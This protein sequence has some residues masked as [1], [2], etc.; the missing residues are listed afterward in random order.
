MHDAALARGHGI[1]AEWL[2][3]SLHAFSGNARRHAQFFKTQRAVAAAIDVYLF[4]ESRFQPQR[5]EGEVFERFQKFRA[6]LQENLFVLAVEIGEHFR[7]ASGAFSISR[8]RVYVYL[9]LE[10]G[11]THHSLQKMS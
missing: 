10:R 3:R 5:P 4:M 8:N 6:A 9:Q 7:V 2:A 1:Q 11:N